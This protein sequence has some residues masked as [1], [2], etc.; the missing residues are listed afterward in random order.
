MTNA[1]ADPPRFRRRPRLMESYERTN[2]IRPAGVLATAC[3]QWQ[4]AWNFPSAKLSSR[5]LEG[6]DDETQLRSRNLSG[7]RTY[8]ELTPIRDKFAPI[9]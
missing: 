9:A 6:S 2:S 4:H 7:N 8:R 5:P 3:T 1:G